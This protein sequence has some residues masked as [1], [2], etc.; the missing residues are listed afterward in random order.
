VCV[1]GGTS[2]FPVMP[3]A[4]GCSKITLVFAVGGGV[5]G[6]V[7]TGGVVTGGVVTGGVVTGGVVTGG[8]VEP[9]EEVALVAL[10]PELLPS[11]PE[12]VAQKHKSARAAAH[13]RK[14]PLCISKPLFVAIT[15]VADYCSIALDGNVSVWGDAAD[16]G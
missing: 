15:I 8:V 7:L 4:L 10:E 3:P 12:S 5:T 2:K 13:I 11:Q 9:V 6:G 14:V 1:A 16:F